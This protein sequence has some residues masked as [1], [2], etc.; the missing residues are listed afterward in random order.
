MK[1]LRIVAVL[2]AVSG[3]ILIVMLGY[4]RAVVFNMWDAKS[5][6]LVLFF[7]KCLSKN[8]ANELLERKAKELQLIG[9]SQKLVRFNENSSFGP[10]RLYPHSQ[11]YSLYND[12]IGCVTILADN[13]LDMDT[14]AETQAK[15]VS[16]WTRL[17]NYER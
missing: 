1:A 13:S 4:K 12:M 8:S 9:H 11:Q 14:R 6:R 10:F 3:V 5:E 15:F 16:L 2:F 7:G 17:E